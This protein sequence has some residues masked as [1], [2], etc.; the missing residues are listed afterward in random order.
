VNFDFFMEPPGGENMPESSISQV[1]TIRG[2][3]RARQPP[4]IW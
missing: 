3:L 2:R 1:S 4:L